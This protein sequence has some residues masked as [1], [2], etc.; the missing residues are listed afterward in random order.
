MKGLNAAVL[1]ALAVGGVV[2]LAG[3]GGAISAAQPAPAGP[4]ASPAG[5]AGFTENGLIQ[6]QARCLGCH[7]NPNVERAPSPQLLR[8]M[9]P[10]RIYEALTT[11]PMKSIG[12]TMPDLLKRQIAESTAGR[13]MGAE[14]AGD[15]RAMPNRCPT[16]PAFG[17]P[18][19]GPNWN[20]WGV[21]AANTRFQPRPGLK[22]SDAPR[23]KLKW[24]FGLPG[25]TSSYSQPTVASGRVFVGADTGYVYALDAETGCVHWSFMAKASVRNAIVIGKLTTGGKA[26]WAAFFGDLRAN[27]YALDARTGKLIWTSKVDEHVTS[28]VT[29]SPALY[30]GRLFVPISSWESSSAKTPDYPCC[31]FQGNVTALDANTGRRIW[32][33]YV[34]DERPKPGKKNSKGVQLYAPAGSAI[35]NTPTVDPKRRA[36]YFGTGDASTYPAPATGD[37]VM[38]V[39]MD[40][41]KVLWSYQVHKGDASLVGCWGEGVTDNCPQSEGPDW[42][43][44]GSPILRNVKG[45]GRTLIIATKPGDILAL[46]PDH[47]GKPLWRINLNGPLAV[48]G[49]PDFKKAPGKGVLFGGAADAETAYFGLQN[50]GMAAV[51]L[52][53]GKILWDAPLNHTPGSR[54]TYPAATSAMP[55]AAFVGGSDG[56]LMAVSTADGSKLWEFDTARP[57]DTVNKVKASGG[58]FGSAG[59][60]VAGGMVFAGSGYAVLFGTPGNVLLA[61]APG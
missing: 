4:P 52:A 32:K 7:G 60:T 24:A 3:L 49:P 45:G 56:K 6:F 1:G 50:G 10:E 12:D 55:G 53:D 37:A 47:A 17:D 19:E 8:A 31:T 22:A 41:G 26:R 30:Q 27:A 46:D 29:A 9:S 44:P 23:L 43:V 18:A 25:S 59:P 5:P 33:R 54:V 42:D 36:V 38:A 20:G 48:V 11:G 21:D 16:N 39:S 28:R 2:A 14:A 15:A 13:L 58:S 35:W 51:R 61:F 34:F 40:T 57:F